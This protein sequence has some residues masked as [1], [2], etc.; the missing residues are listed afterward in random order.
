V[1]GFCLVLQVLLNL[2]S[3]PFADHCSHRGS[4]A[5][6]FLVYIFFFFLISSTPEQ[7]PEAATAE[8]DAHHDRFSTFSQVQPQLQQEGQSSP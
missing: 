6:L 4:S 1:R 5:D 3:M 8:D 2:I 7:R